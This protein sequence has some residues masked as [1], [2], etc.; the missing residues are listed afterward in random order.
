[1]KY[2]VLLLYPD[3]VADTFGHETYLAHVE[4]EDTKEAIDLAQQEIANT[5]HA[6]RQDFYPLLVVY[7]WH[8]DLI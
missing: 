1:M 5:I 2:T 4:A 7:G 6:E 3:Y 8:D